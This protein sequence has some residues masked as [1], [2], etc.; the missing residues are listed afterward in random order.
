MYSPFEEQGELIV[1]IDND[2]PVRFD[3]YY[4]NQ[5]ATKNKIISDVF[6]KGDA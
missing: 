1:R 2:G 4:K 5:G 6:V 3:G